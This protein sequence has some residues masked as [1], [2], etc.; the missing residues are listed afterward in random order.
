MSP[1]RRVAPRPTHRAWAVCSPGLE[2][3][4]AAELRS[5]GAKPIQVGSGGVAFGATTRQLYAANLWLRVA[6]RVVLRLPPFTA[7]TFDQLERHASELPWADFLAPGTVPTFRVTS[8]A[9]RLYHTDAIAERLGNGV[10]RAVGWPRTAEREQ[11]V[12]VRAQRDSFTV[13]I[14]ASGEPLHKRGYRQAVAKAPLRETLAAAMVLASGYDGTAP[15]L[16][17][18]CG[19]GT[20]LIEAAMLA[21]SM[22]PGAGRTFAFGDWPCFEGGTWGSVLGEA[23]ERERLDLAIPPIIGSDRDAGAV[24]AA[25]ANAERA[26][27]DDAVAFTV[28]SVSDLEPPVGSITGW[29]ITNPPYGRRVGHDQGTAGRAADPAGTAAAKAHDRDLRDLYARFGAVCRDLL[30]GWT[31]GLLSADRKLT[32]HARLAGLAERFATDNGGIPVRFLTGPSA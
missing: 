13:S 9:S 17:P 11:L 22:A 3:L 27:V 19:S 14:D 30:P 15:L 21:R 7:T 10:D 25:T 28:R 12:V 24:A 6:N 31:V 4:L 26:G 32:G 5:L 16:D 8:S 20:I 2:G 23:A 1:A 29:V 18:F